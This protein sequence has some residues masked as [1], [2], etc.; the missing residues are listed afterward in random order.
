VYAERIKRVVIAER[1]LDVYNSLEAALA[2]QM[3]AIHW[4]TMT[5]AQRLNHVKTIPQ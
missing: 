5:F 1:L 4:T 3:A 2:A